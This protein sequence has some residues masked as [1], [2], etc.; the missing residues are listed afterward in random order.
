LA[1]VSFRSLS[2]RLTLTAFE[3]EHV[4]YPGDIERGV[5]R[6]FAQPSWKDEMPKIEAGRVQV[7]DDDSKE[8]AEVPSYVLVPKI[9]AGRVQVADDDSKEDAEVPSYVLVSEEPSLLRDGDMYE[10]AETED[11]WE[12][13]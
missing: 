3:Q 2:S 5:V 4:Q 7:A 8:D 6:Y 12:L 9:E 1:S 11:E 10:E 13:V